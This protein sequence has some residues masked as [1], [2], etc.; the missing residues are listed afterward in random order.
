MNVRGIIF[1]INGTLIDI[2]TNEED[3][4]VYRILSN[5]LSYQGMLS[6]GDV[7]DLYCRILEEQRRS[8]KEHHPE[9]DAGGI[10]REIMRRCATCFTRRLPAEKLVRLPLFPAEAQALSRGP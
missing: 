10:F 3:D 5:L 8:R 9:F 2:K 6:P 4:E 1:D 7:K